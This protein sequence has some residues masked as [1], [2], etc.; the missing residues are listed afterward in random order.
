MG[1]VPCGQAGQR[2]EGLIQVLD[3]PATT[4]PRGVSIQGSAS[5][6][7]VAARLRRCE[8]AM[9]TLLLLSADGIS[10]AMWRLHVKAYLKRGCRVVVL[11]DMDAA[12]Q[13]VGHGVDEQHYAELRSQ[14]G[15]SE[16]K[17]SLEGG[18]ALARAIQSLP[19]E[20][21][22]VWNVPVFDLAYAD[23]GMFAA[24]QAA[25]ARTQDVLFIHNCTSAWRHGAVGLADTQ[26]SFVD[27]DYVAGYEVANRMNYRVLGVL[28]P[29]MQDALEGLAQGPRRMFS[30]QWQV[31]QADGQ[32]HCFAGE[33]SDIPFREDV[34]RATA[35][36][37]VLAAPAVPA[38]VAVPPEA[39]ALVSA[40]HR[41]GFLTRLMSG[42]CRK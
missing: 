36:F 7:Q 42:F 34:V 8:L 20:A 32:F 12:N 22:L 2:Q 40:K 13:L 37:S 5:A 4:K 10:S 21:V 27:F 23:P 28:L 39:S 35:C 15:F 38:G 31:A 14:T 29:Q 19:P 16:L 3:S 24:L 33:L 41:A 9:K 1:G 30:G 17:F 6:V 26:V 25:A 11:S 18:K